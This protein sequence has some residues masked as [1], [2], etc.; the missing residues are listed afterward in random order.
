MGVWVCGGVLCLLTGQN[1]GQPATT[2]IRILATRHIVVPV[3]LNGKGPFRLG[4]DTGSP[5]TFINAATA[6]RL[7]I[8]TAAAAQAPSMAGLRTVAQLKSVQ[9]GDAKVENVN[10]FVLDHPALDMMSQFTGPIDGLIGYSFF[11]RF[12]V[13]LDYQAKTITFGPSRYEPEDVIASVMRRMMF[14]G[15]QRRVITPSGLWGI[16]VKADSQPGVIVMKVFDGGAAA[17]AGLKAGDRI[18]T[19]DGRW[20]DSVR[21]CYEAAEMVKPGESPK[22]VFQRGGHAQT[23]TIRLRDGL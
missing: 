4:F 15:N 7:G 14:S 13:T 2:P 1:P 5:I 9:V 6:R 19:L 11:G 16:A 20:T 22:I 18:M 21:D 12:K 10:V 8:I 3:I 17:G 23:I